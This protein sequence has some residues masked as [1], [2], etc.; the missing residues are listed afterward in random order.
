[1]NSHALKSP[2]Y[3]YKFSQH[4]SKLLKIPRPNS[5]RLN[6]CKNGADHAKHPWQI[7]SSV[8][9]RVFKTLQDQNP[10]VK[11]KGW[12]FTPQKTEN[13]SFFQEISRNNLHSQP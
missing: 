10:E 7:S 8:E 6:Q 11:T 2:H 12:K 13:K 1:M 9:Q 3:N 4:D 5:L